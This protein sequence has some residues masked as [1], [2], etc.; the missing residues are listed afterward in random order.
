LLKSQNVITFETQAMTVKNT[1]QI[2]ANPIIKR[3]TIDDLRQKILKFN[4]D[5]KNL[6]VLNRSKIIKEVM[7][8]DINHPNSIDLIQSI[9]EEVD[10][11]KPISEEIEKFFSLNEDKKSKVSITLEDKKC[12]CF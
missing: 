2:N 6:Q 5:F 7:L 1:L 12:F 10:I 4:N 8:V 9:S 3:I 11:I